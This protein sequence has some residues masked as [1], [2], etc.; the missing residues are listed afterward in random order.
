MK[1]VRVY[2]PYYRYLTLT[3]SISPS[4]PLLPFAHLSTSSSLAATILLS[5]TAYLGLGFIQL[6]GF[7]PAYDDSVVGLLFLICLI[8]TA[9]RDMR[10]VRPVPCPSLPNGCSPFF[11]S[12]AVPPYKVE[13]FPPQST[14]RS[15]PV[16]IE[17]VLGRFC[18]TIL[19]TPSWTHSLPPSVIIFIFERSMQSTTGT[20]LRLISFG[21][22]LSFVLRMVLN[23]RLDG[24]GA[25]VLSQLKIVETMMHRIQYDL[26]P[27]DPDKAVLPHECFDMMGGSDMGG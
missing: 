18:L 21:M 8:Y 7:I 10:H 11:I 6:K 1:V 5:P 9:F 16:L 27:D 25:R 19:A 17:M 3:T 12:Q 23:L 26:Y 4:H 14:Y 15:I 24:G 20:G 13:F 22:C 2:E